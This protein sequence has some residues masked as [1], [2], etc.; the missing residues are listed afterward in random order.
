MDPGM[1]GFPAHVFLSHS[2]SHS[3]PNAYAILGGWGNAWRDRREFV[4]AVDY[5]A[6]Y[7]LW[8][9]TVHQLQ[10]PLFARAVEA[11][12]SCQRRDESPVS[13]LPDECLYYIFNMCRWD[14]FGDTPQT[15]QLRRRQS[16]RKAQQ[17]AVR[18]AEALREASVQEM[19]P[20]AP[21]SEEHDKDRSCCQQQRACVESTRRSGTDRDGGNGQESESEDEFGS[22]EEMADHERNSDALDEDAADDEDVDDEEDDN[23][24]DEEDDDGDEDFVDDSDHISTGSEESDWERAHGYRADNRVLRVV[25]S[26]SEEDSD[27][28]DEEIQLDTDA[29][30]GRG[31]W[32]RRSLNRIHV[33]RAMAHRT[34]DDHD[35]HGEELDD[36]E[37]EVEF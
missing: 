32:F 27:D 28:S 17:R 31:G 18:Q 13:R 1:D 21:A 12:L 36:E 14:W 37:M 24:D 2:L 22:D 29:L 19:A 25:L 30:G 33:L 26:D 23:D 15:M 16:R 9:P 8:T 7:R 3:L 4:G 35:R 34:Q 6:R 11:M 10:G 20:N 5:A